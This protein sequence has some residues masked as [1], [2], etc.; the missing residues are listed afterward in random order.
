VTCTDL[1]AMSGRYGHMSAARYGAVP[2]PFAH[3]AAPELA[4]RMLLGALCKAAGG[5]GRRI[6]PLLCV[7]FADFYARVAVVVRDCAADEE[8]RC[9]ARSPHH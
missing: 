5:A 2:L 6:E 3:K 7:T 8:M 9:D 4:M 1:G